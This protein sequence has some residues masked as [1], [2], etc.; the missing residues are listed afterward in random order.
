LICLDGAQ[1]IQTMGRPLPSNLSIAIPSKQ[2]GLVRVHSFLFSSLVILV[3]LFITNAVKAQVIVETFE[4]FTATS[5]LASPRATRLHTVTASSSTIGITGTTE[6]T[7]SAETTKTNSAVGGLGLTK[8][9][10]SFDSYYTLSTC[11]KTSSSTTLGPDSTGNFTWFYGASAAV[12]AISISS[13]PT[14]GSGFHSNAYYLVMPTTSTLITPIIPQGISVVTFWVNRVAVTGNVIEVG[15][16]TTATSTSSTTSATHTGAI[17]STS[18]STTTAAANNTATYPTHSSAATTVFSNISSFTTSGVRF[19]TSTHSSLFT[20]RSSGTSTLT[21]STTIASASN[22]ANWDVFQVVYTIPTSLQSAPAQILITANG[23]TINID[24]IEVFSSDIAPPGTWTGN[25]STDWANPLN[26]AYNQ[27]PTA[28]SNVVIPNVAN[29]NFPVL[30]T[31]AEINNLTINTSAT[32]SINGFDLVIDG[33]VN[34]LGKFIGSATSDLEF[35]SASSGTIYFT[36]FPG[37]I[38]SFTLDD[39]A[40]IALGSSLEIVSSGIVTVG[41]TTG[42]TL[43]TNGYLILQSDNNGSARVDVMPVDGT[44][45]SLSTISGSVNVLCY[46]HS[47]NSGISSAL[48]GWRLLTAPITNYGL[49]TP[50]SIYSGWQNGGVNVSGQ[51]TMI[52]G[53]ASVATGG[54]GNGLDAGINANY[55][56]YTW[57][58]ATQKLVAVSNTKAGISNSN[59]ADTA[60]NIGY[61]IFVRGDRTPNTVNLPW[62]ATINNTTL[63][64]SGPLQL[65]DQL[66]SSSTGVISAT[67][68]GLSLIGNPF[69]SSIDFSQVAGDDGTGSPDASSGLNNVLNRIY[70]WNSNLSGSQGVGGYTCIDDANYDGNYSKNLD[71]VAGTSLGS[72]TTADLSIQSGQAFFVQTGITAAA[73][74]T[75][76]EATKSTTNNFIYRP[77]IGNGSN[78]NKIPIPSFSS[79]LSLLNSD[80]TT[81]L[82]DGVLAQFKNGYCDCVDNIDAPKFSNIDEMFS[83]SRE[84]KQICIE[85]RSDLTKAD[86]LFLTLQQMSQR[87]YRF[88]FAT[89]LANHPGIGAHL[90]DSHTNAH[91]PLNM[92]GTNTLDFAIDS[93]TTSQ[94]S[95]RFMVVFGAVN[96]AP[97]YTYITAHKEGNTIPV[98]WSVSNDSSMTGYALQRSVDGI[99]YTT[100]YTATA[101]HNGNGYNWID[102]NP[103][104]GTNY[105]RVLS[106]DVLNEQSY[107]ST[108]SVG[109]ATLNPSGITVYPNPIQNNR[110]GIALNNMTAGTYHYNLLN[111][112]GQQIQ[113]GSFTH[114]GGNATTSI[115]ITH[116]FSN[117]TYRLEII[118]PDNTTTVINVLY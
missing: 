27:V 1:Q 106:T 91:T 105:Y 9:T 102:A 17:T 10:S 37:L 94:A 110:I 101:Q 77:I 111:D 109:I 5:L 52:T 104:T 71:S 53:P 48:R 69:A 41:N 63:T 59:G 47:T 112:L 14:S 100:V 97:V 34:G 103:A 117:G 70:V 31:S 33:A 90:E 54:A 76:K 12:A 13:N 30:S 75:I 16:R 98:E 38:D 28:S 92:S 51:G 4:E 64:S 84:G 19:T 62:L 43:T 15:I 96:I 86:T 23:A 3:S 2:C 45:K 73:S 89:T 115:L 85:R 114:S 24:D 49:A 93:S 40:S 25:V 82:T 55:S 78:V 65:G 57:K 107:S 113:T 87:N 68:N 74:I 42:A 20:T 108:V 67:A 36:T 11:S 50:F 26:W 83:L 66:F 56:M 18:V 44:G 81:S 22:S 72:A 99:N 95:N 39:G 58:V 80:G 32:L 79:T 118:Q 46:I 7:S 88:N 29:T 6:T 60:D 8:T 116:P 21:S 35:G 61:F